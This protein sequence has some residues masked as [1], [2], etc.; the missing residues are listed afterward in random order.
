[1][2]DLKHKAMTNLLK[3]I[4]TINCLN[5]LFGL[6]DWMKY[7]KDPEETAEITSLGVISMM[8]AICKVQQTIQMS[9]RGI[10]DKDDFFDNKVENLRNLNKE[11]YGI[12]MLELKK[13][14]W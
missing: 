7:D 1:M 10:I 6:H 5:G 3:T 8:K 4:R 12:V 13:I 14:L 2:N 9:P 11:K